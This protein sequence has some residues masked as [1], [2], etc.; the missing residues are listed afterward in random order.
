MDA[1]VERLENY[2]ESE[3]GECRSEDV[4]R[5]LREL[6]RTR[7]EGESGFEAELDV[8]SALADDTRYRLVRSLVAAD[9]ELCVCELSSL[10]DVSDSALSHALRRLSEAGLVKG[11]KQ[12]RWKKYGA[13]NRAVALT[14]VVGGAV[15]D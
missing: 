15:D 7:E 9:G 5:R 14:T 11:R 4:E 13:T 10:V 8:L 12:G 3:L 6:E 1:E 2:L